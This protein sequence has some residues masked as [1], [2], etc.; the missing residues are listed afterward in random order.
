ML[1]ENRR[2][3]SAILTF[4]VGKEL[5]CSYIYIRIDICTLLLYLH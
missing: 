5:G 1:E 2:N 3:S 4:I